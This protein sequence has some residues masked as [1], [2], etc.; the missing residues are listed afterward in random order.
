MENFEAEDDYYVEEDY[1]SDGST[2]S[3]LHYLNEELHRAD[4]PAITTFFRDSGNISCVDYYYHGYRHR[5]EN[6][7]PSYIRYNEKGDIEIQRYFFRGKSHRVNGPSYTRFEFKLGSSD[8]TRIPEIERWCQHGDL[9]R[10]NGPALVDRYTTGKLKAQEYFKHDMY[11]RIDGP[12]IL[13]CDEDGNI[14]VQRYIVNDI[15][16]TETLREA[17][18]IDEQGNCLDQTALEMTLSMM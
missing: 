14:T 8:G 12:A 3:R 4:G 13:H 6:E 17:G 2:K 11:H 9:H 7:G 16:V 18:I 5:D 15:E 10:D 1:F